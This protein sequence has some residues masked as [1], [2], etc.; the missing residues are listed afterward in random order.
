MPLTVHPLTPERLTD[1][2]A[3]FQARG[4]SVAKNCYCMYYRVS[5]KPSG[6]ETGETRTSWNRA[7]MAK[8]AAGETPPGL[9][10]YKDGRPAGWISL[11]PRKDFVR[12]ANSPTMRSIDDKPVWSIICFVVPSEYRKQ[13]VAHELLAAAVDFAKA[14][15]A[16]LLEAYPVDRDA[17]EAPN[18][19][20]FGSCSM[21]VKAGFAEVARHKH[22][23]PI[24][25][26]ELTRG[27]KAGA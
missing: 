2:D 16:T 24:V 6:L 22:T 1:L 17:P 11:G 23:R 10:G 5:G 25:R 13:G 21:F 14:R 20:W 12:L 8:L 3:V 4:C 19:P 26:L 9:L 15:G 7:E 18:A 27:R